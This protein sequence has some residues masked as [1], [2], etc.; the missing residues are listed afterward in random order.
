[1]FAFL[2]PRPASRVIKISGLIKAKK[3]YLNNKGKK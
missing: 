1:M 3:N 2:V